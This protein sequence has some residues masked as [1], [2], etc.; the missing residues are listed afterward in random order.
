MDR[1]A[2]LEESARKDRADLSAA[3]RLVPRGRAEWMVRR[4][5]DLLD[6][7][8]AATGGAKRVAPLSAPST[9]TSTA[10]WMEDL[11]QD[12]SPLTFFERRVLRLRPDL[13]PDHA[14]LETEACW[15]EV[16]A[17]VARVVTWRSAGSAND[18]VEEARA[19]DGA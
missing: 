2:E 11:R 17:G 16:R 5:I 9:T 1:W 12:L 3:L 7:A 18:L 10:E 19:V 14:Q 15:P 13:V 6:L 8:H 4:A